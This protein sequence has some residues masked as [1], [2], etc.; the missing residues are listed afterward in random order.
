MKALYVIVFIYRLYFIFFI[1]QYPLVTTY[2]QY[3]HY[4]STQI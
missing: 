1:I 3:R 2:Y 4:L